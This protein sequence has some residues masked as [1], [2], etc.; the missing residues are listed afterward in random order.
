MNKRQKKKQKDNELRKKALFVLSN[1]EGNFII[2][3]AKKYWNRGDK[4]KMGFMQNDIT[5]D[6]ISCDYIHELGFEFIGWI[7][8][9]NG[10]LEIR[11]SW[12]NKNHLVSA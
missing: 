10:N 1:I 8:N 3:V 5:E 7:E 11:K 2:Y 6:Y 4:L 9:M 12:N